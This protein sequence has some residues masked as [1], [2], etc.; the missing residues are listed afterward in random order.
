MYSR[1]PSPSDLDLEPLKLI[2]L[3]KSVVLQGQ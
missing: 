2:L 1:F 3:K